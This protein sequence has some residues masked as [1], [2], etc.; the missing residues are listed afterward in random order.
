MTDFEFHHTL[1]DTPQLE[2]NIYRLR[3]SGV[4]ERSLRKTVQRFGLRG[5]GRGIEI[6]K[7]DSEFIYSEGRFVVRL[8]RLSGALRYYDRMRWQVDDGESQIQLPDDEAV[9]IAQ[10]F[11]KETELVP[12]DECKPLKVT[13]L[14]SETCRR[15]D[16]QGERRIIDAGVLFQRTIGGVPVDGPGG[17]V[18]VYLDHKGEVTGCDRIW[19]KIRE[20][21]RPVPVDKLRSPRYAE[22][23][24]KRYWSPYGLRRVRTEEMRFGYFELGR[25]DA[26]RFLQPAYIVPLRLTSDDERMVMKSVHVATAARE[27]VGRLMPRRKVLSPEPPTRG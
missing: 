4:S 26:Q 23:S 16:D 10:E 1:S 9:D 3:G 25:S 8:W 11:V 15:D 5:I 2:T 22:R 21:H 7:T 27:P 24:L 17:K 18:M 14:Y 12:L 20:V 19:R 6:Q 13:H